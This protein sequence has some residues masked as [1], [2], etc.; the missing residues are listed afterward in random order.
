MTTDP[1]TG[2]NIL[3]LYR[4]YRTAEISLTGFYPFS[5]LTSAPSLEGAG[6]NAINKQTKQ[7]QAH[8]PNNPGG[9]QLTQNYP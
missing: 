2:G 6:T 1:N 9:G 5:T 7:T 3:A 4:T 8:N